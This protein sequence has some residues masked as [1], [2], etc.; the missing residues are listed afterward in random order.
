MNFQRTDMTAAA[1]RARHK[2]L[3]EETDLQQLRVEQKETQMKPWALHT[4]TRNSLRIIVHRIIC[5][6]CEGEQFR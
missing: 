3:Q 5:Y 1:A 6:H 2:S 4:C